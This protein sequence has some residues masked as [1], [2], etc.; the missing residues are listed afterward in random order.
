LIL[1]EKLFQVSWFT[2]N[3]KSPGFYLVTEIWDDRLFFILWFSTNAVW[4]GIK[5]LWSCKCVFHEK[6]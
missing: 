5:M 6:I 1:N 3:V 2:W 4:R